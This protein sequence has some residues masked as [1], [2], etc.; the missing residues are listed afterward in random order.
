MASDEF[1]LRKKINSTQIL[2][3]N[4]RGKKKLYKLLFFFFLRP[5]IAWYQT[6]WKYYKKSKYSHALIVVAL[7]L[8]HVRHF[9]YN[10]DSIPQGS[11]IHGIS[12]ARILEWVAIS[13]T[14][15][16]SWPRGWTH[17]SCLKGLFFTTEPPGKPM[18]SLIYMKKNSK[19]IL[20]NWIQ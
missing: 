5:S 15:G 1:H 11:S 20:A 12:Q 18:P 6:R 8:H 17:I 13:F 9:C 19:Q 3:E 10:M 4:W 2:S 7:L 14:S 16:S